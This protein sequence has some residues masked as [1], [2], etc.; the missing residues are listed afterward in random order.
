[1]DAVHDSGA[2]PVGARFAALARRVLGA[3]EATVVLGRDLRALRDDPRTAAFLSAPLTGVHGTV[4]GALC[5]ASHEPR[6]WTP[7]DE[8][9]LGELAAACSESLALLAARRRARAG[10]HAAALH[11]R[12]A[13]TAYA[14]SSLLLQASSALA[15]TSTVADIV[16]AVRDLA[17]GM[18]DPAFVAMSLVAPDGDLVLATRE[19]LPPSVVERFRRY[20]GPD[21]TP[22][23]LA[24]STREIVLIPDAAGVARRTPAVA[25]V[26]AEL[27]WQSSA[28]VPLPGPGGPLGALTFV[29]REPH[30]PDDG[31]QTLLAALGGYVAQALQRAYH[32]REREGVASTLQRAMLTDL[33]AVPPFELAAR[34]QPAARGEQVGGDWY[35]AVR[36]PDGHLALVVGDVAGHDM[37]AATHM[38]QLRSMLRGF[39]VDRAEPPSALLRRLDTAT[40]RLGRPVPTT[41]VLACLEPDTHVLRWANAGH[42]PPVLLPP[43]G[44]PV[45]LP[46]RD[47]L[48]GVARRLERTDRDRAVPPGS[49]LLFYTDGLL[50]TRGQVIDEREAELLTLLRGQ[51]TTPLP[52]LL[53]LLLHKIAGDDHEDDVAML[54]V[55]TP[56]V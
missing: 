34:Y 24:V 42:P 18:L 12:A 38:G 16:A 32:L 21:L 44:T 13:E 43:E 48:L 27:G 7:S 55:R 5:V 6:Q 36:L 51:G 10:E 22:S 4:V 47:P 35:D 33:P 2:D 11:E 20:P 52:E 3:A 49:T 46:G 31:E 19:G 40:R 1:M 25:P 53:D 45:V 14:R 56:R 54:A 17:T 50:E 39:L 41:A 30:T 9:L 28:S 37:R 26:F 29:W 23:A 15:A 8:E